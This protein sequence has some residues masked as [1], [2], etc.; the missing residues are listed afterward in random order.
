MGN[1]PWYSNYSQNNNSWANT[2]QSNQQ[3]NQ[4]PNLS[5]AEWLSFSD[6]QHQNFQNPSPS[7]Q[8]EVEYEKFS[9]ISKTTPMENAKNVYI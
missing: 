5:E 3:I 7:N 9:Q 8:K 2:N 4:K 6:H 1:N